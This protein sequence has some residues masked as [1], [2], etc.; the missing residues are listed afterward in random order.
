VLYQ[1]REAEKAKAREEG[2]VVPPEEFTDR[3]PT[4]KY[5]F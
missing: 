1:K 5:Q 3:A 4:F 2:V